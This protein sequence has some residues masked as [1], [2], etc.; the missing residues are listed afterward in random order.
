M[1]RL[2]DFQ[3]ESL[4]TEDQTT[5]K[6]VHG[7]ITRLE[8]ESKAKKIYQNP[9][10]TICWKLG[11]IDEDRERQLISCSSNGDIYCW[12]PADEELLYHVKEDNEIYCSDYSNYFNWFATAGGD[13]RIRIYDDITQKN[14]QTFYGAGDDILGHCN[15]IFSVKF[16]PEDSNIL[17]SGGWDNLVYIWDLRQEG[18]V[19]HILG[20]NVSGESLDIYG[21]H[22]VAGSYNNE[23]NLCLMSIKDSKIKK[24]IEWYDSDFYKDMELS[25]PCVYAAQFSKPD[26]SYIIAGGT[27]RNE[28]RIFKNIDNF[29]EIVGIGSISNLSGACISIDSAHAHPNKFAIGCSNGTLKCFRIQES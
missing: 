9:I 20:P 17:I 15:R 1:V 23:Q 4:I 21:D 13:C 7:V 18:P 25:P 29:S 8:A 26:A 2:I 19:S 16:H 27:S 10:T 5:P 3:H 24:N 22:I 28:V 14:I 6:K 12:R 11:E